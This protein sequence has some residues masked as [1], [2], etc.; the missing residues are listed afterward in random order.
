MKK[1]TNT[2]VRVLVNGNYGHVD[3]VVELSSDEL[4][5][6]IAS[7]QVDQNKDA[8]AYAKSLAK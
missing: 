1:Q 5:S 4:A 2:E 6:A 3:Q 7:G 8:V